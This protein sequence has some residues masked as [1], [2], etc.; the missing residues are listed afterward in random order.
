MGTRCPDL[1][2]IDDPFIPVLFGAGAKA[3]HVRTAGGFREKLAPDFVTAHGRADKALLRFFRAPGH[4]S[5]NAH[6]K[7]DGEDA[8]RHEVVRFFLAVDDVLNG[9]AATAAPLLR[10]DDA[11]ITGDR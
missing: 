6:A 8:A 5:R 10:P 7:A 4:H 3:G 9:G 1:L 11:G 2:A